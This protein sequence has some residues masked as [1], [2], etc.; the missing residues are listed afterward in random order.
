MM[1]EEQMITAMWKMLRTT[2]KVCA[3][4]LVVLN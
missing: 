1:M 3:L 2:A 4:L